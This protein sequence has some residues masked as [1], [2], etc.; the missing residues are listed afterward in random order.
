MHRATASPRF[1]AIPYLLFCSHLLYSYTLSPLRGGVTRQTNPDTPT[2]VKGGRVGRHCRGDPPAEV[3]CLFKYG[4]FQIRAGG[5]RG[6]MQLSTRSRM[7]PVFENV[8]V[9]AGNLIV[10][11]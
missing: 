11:L 2:C 1:L 9:F 3:L 7:P 4:Q 10:V 8:L 6:A 5:P